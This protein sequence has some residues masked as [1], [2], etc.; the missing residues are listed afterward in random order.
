MEKGG[1][2][3]SYG[4]NWWDLWLLRDFILRHLKDRDG[5]KA[6]ERELWDVV[7]KEARVYQSFSEKPD[8]GTFKMSWS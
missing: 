2:D 8:S 1:F 4:S 6:F 5:D 7:L 3:F